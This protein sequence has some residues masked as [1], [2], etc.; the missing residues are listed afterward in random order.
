MLT[1]HQKSKV[2]RWQYAKYEQKIWHIAHARQTSPGIQR[3][4]VS[5]SITSATSKKSLVPFK[6][7]SRRW[8]QGCCWCWMSAVTAACRCVPMGP[9]S[10]NANATPY[11]MVGS[12]SRGGRGAEWDDARR[13]A[14][15]GVKVHAVSQLRIRTHKHTHT[16]PNLTLYSYI[17][18]GL[19][20][21]V[22]ITS[23]CHNAIRNDC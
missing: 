4:S 11:T 15:G 13:W 21:S 10:G 18:S 20:H 14:P 7:T 12:G 19:E 22:S 1:V 23:A 6:T 5:L 3:V 9:A 17:L 8:L 16:Q 2:N